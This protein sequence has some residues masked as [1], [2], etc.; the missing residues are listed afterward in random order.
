MTGVENMSFGSRLRDARTSRGMT[1]QK[2]ADKLEISINSVANYERGISFPKSDCLYKIFS[3]LGYNP[4]YFFQDEIENKGSFW[5]EE[6][7]ILEIYRHLNEDNR[8]YIRTV[9]KHEEDRN[10]DISNYSGVKTCI[11]LDVSES[12]MGKLVSCDKWERFNA[13]NM[14]DNADFM[15][16]VYGDCLRPEI[17]NGDYIF[18][19]YAPDIPNGKWGMFNVS[20][21]SVIARR[22][23]N[24]I[25]AV[26]GKGFEFSDRN[27]K[28]SPYG[29]ITAIYKIRKNR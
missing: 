17:N 14:P 23:G 18:I 28:V 22:L 24:K 11:R 12:S 21:Y 15:F 19:R 6:S 8:R 3:S 20:G 16:R 5:F 27:K 10:V 9:L 7:G 2:F 26:D 1:Q 4:D 29:R 25:I 13:P